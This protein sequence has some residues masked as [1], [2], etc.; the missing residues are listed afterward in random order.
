THPGPFIDEFDNESDEDDDAYVEILLVTPIRSATVI[1][2]LG[3]QG[4]SSTAL[5][6]E[7]PST[8]GNVIMVDVAAT[9]F[10]SA[11][12]LR[13]SSRPANSFRDVFKDTIHTNFFPFSAGPYCAAYPEGGVAGNYKLT[14]EEWDAPYRP[15]FRVLTKEI[16]KDPIVY[17]TMLDQFPHREKWSGSK[18][19]LMII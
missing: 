14:R 10:V 1:P 8:R 9:S 6:A 11:S 16:F 13:P 18:P 15:T 19:C 3:N 17:N 7:G 5:A 2:S 4:G 12:R